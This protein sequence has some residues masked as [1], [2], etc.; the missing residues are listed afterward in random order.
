MTP[1]GY[2][3]LNQYYNLLLPKLYVEVYQDPQ[4]DTEK[5]ISYGASKRK[6][7]PGTRKQ[8]QTPF[9]HMVLA[10]KYQ[11]IRLHFF[12]AMFQKVDV[13]ALTAFIADKP[14]SKYN[15]VIWYLYEWLTEKRLDLND[16]TQGNYIKLFEDDFYYTIANGDKKKRTRVINNAIGTK[17]FCPTIRKTKEV[18][19]LEDIDVYQTAYAE[20]Q[21]LGDP[22]TAD[23]LGRSINYLYTKETKSSNEIERETP[24]KH[25]MKRF[26]NVIKNVGLFELTKEKLIDLQNKIVEENKRANDYR[27]DEI[28][29]G[30]TI[31]RLG[32]I[33]ED[34][35][36]IGA[37]AK[38]VPSIMHGLLKTH[39]RLMIDAKVP[40]LIHATAISFGEVYIHPLDDGNGR[41]HRYLIHDVMKQR[42]P[43]QKFIIPISAAILKNQKQYDSV[44][45]TISRPILAMLDWELDS[46]NNNKLIV[47]NDIDYMYRYPD[48][49]EH[50]KFVYDMMTKAISDELVE[51]IGLLV[52]FDA[53][54]SAINNLTDIPNNTLDK[55]TSIIIN[56]GGKVSKAKHKFVA[57]H[58]DQENLMVIEE[59]SVK[60][61]QTMKARINID[62]QKLM[63]KK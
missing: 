38:H 54:K 18:K 60:L 5:L 11:G 9:E 23:V 26:L 12:S 45:E 25:K 16:L 57:S 56:G 13:N 39:E 35:H 53:I 15:R 32:G 20:M 50:V 19:A 1:L 36:Y 30:S 59:L 61:I 4:A 52:V 48:Y 6:I 17:D 44:L 24:V 33:D 37:L 14:N 51:E 8:A 7:I 46:E 3:Y 62:V 34:V 31:H 41:I 21:K 63:D 42:E 2:T 43:E 27:T 22:L 29:V 40:A 55:I 10:I 58:I 49:T 28:Y 47:H